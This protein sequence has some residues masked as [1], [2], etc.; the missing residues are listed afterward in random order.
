MSNSVTH[1]YVI[2]CQGLAGVL[3]DCILWSFCRPWRGRCVVEGAI[4]TKTVDT[5]GLVVR[6]DMKVDRA[7][8]K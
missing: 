4:G 7:S 1:L 8:G 6:R 2:L 3:V 5:Q